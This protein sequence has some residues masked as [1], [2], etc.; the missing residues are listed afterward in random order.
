MNFSGLADS[1]KI[2][3]PWIDLMLFHY[4]CQGILD[5]SPA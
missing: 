1:H 4:E 3:E 2:G 5:R